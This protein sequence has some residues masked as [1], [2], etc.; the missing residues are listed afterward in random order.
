MNRTA[1]ADFY[2]PHSPH[3]LTPIC[4]PLQLPKIANLKTHLFLHITTMI[5]TRARPIRPLTLQHLHIAT[6][7]RYADAQVIHDKLV[8]KFLDCKRDQKESPD[9]VLLTFQMMPVYTMGRRQSGE[10]ALRSDPKPHSSIPE[11]PAQSSQDGASSDPGADTE[12]DI[13]TADIVHT[14]RGGETTFHGPGQIVAYPILDLKQ[15]RK[16]NDDGTDSPFTPKCYISLLESSIISALAQ[17]QIF[18]TRTENPGV[19]TMDGESKVAAVGVNI[20]RNITSHGICLNVNNNLSWFD[21]IVP[22]GLDEKKVTNVHSL[23]P[24]VK[25][26]EVVHDYAYSL[27]NYLDVNYKRVDPKDAK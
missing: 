2:P 18:T 15:F 25:F 9:P 4:V 21:H 16:I 3:T 22:C 23:G 14:Q 5:W 8:R 24:P 20:R 6:P 10:D 1:F 19:W 12:I 13:S 27:A 26:E 11:T 17:Y 7:I